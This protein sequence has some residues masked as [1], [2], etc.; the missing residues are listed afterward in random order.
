MAAN[1]TDLRQSKTE[2]MVVTSFPEVTVFVGIGSNLAE[3]VTQVNQAIDALKAI[4]STRLV[5][6]S[7]WYGSSPSGGP[8]KQPDYVNGVACLH[9]TLAP[10]D[11]LEALQAIEQRQGRQ[12]LTRWGART[13]DLDLLLY[14]DMEIQDERLTVPHPRLAER[15][16]VLVPLSDIASHL[17]LPNGHSVKS[18]LAGIST[19]GVWPLTPSDAAR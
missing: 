11:L 4:P 18:L 14:G 19:I 17:V 16:F 2:F 3:P 6:Q 7:P 8:E 9:T 12:R 1:A 10:H 13:L 5:T 15:A